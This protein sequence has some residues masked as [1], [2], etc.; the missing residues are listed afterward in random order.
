MELY[1]GHFIPYALRKSIVVTLLLHNFLFLFLIGCYCT[2]LLRSANSWVLNLMLQ[3]YKAAGE[4]TI[5]LAGAEYGSGS[6]RDWAA[7]GPMLLVSWSLLLRNIR[8]VICCVV[9]INFPFFFPFLI[10]EWKQWSQ[11]AL[12]ESIVV[13]LLVWASFLFVSSPVKMQ[14]L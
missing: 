3:R 10:R 12:R 1:F 7:K 4:A 9:A 11:R 2:L 6:S 13:T 5:V 14:T 8:L